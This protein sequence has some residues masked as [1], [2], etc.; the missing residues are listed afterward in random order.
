[1]TKKK[2]ELEPEYIEMLGNVTDSEIS[3]LSGVSVYYVRKERLSRG[4]DGSKKRSR[5]MGADTLEAGGYLEL[6]GKIS[7][8][9]LARRAGVSASSVKY[10]RQ[11]M[12]IKPLSKSARRVGFNYDHLLEH[13][14]NR[15]IAEMLGITQEAVG[16]RRKAVK[17]GRKRHSGSMESLF[18]HYQDDQLAELWQVPVEVVKQRRSEF[19]F[20]EPLRRAETPEIKAVRIAPEDLSR[21]REIG[22]GSSAGGISKALN[23]YNEKPRT[24]CPENIEEPTPE[25]ITAF[26]EQ[27]QKKMGM[28]I[29]AAQDHC[30][31]MVH[32]TRRGWQSWERGERRMHPAFWELA[33]IKSGL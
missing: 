26:R 15:E 25:Q 33:Q 6:L 31:N 1:M 24:I 23:A 20:K 7:D 27:V 5:Y 9:E 16:Q 14:S 30:A 10:V 29:T 17:S 4:I 22:N 3:R 18:S 2:K 8:T 12:G 28:K 21:A 11:K 32:A 13:Y 19:Q